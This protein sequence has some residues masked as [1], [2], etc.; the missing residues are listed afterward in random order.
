MSFVRINRNLGSQQR[1]EISATKTLFGR[2]D[3]NEITV[4]E[5]IM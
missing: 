4:T 2:N 3:F 1:T 5:E